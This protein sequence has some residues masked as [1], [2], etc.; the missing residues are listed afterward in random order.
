MRAPL[1]PGLNIEMGAR[2][3]GPQKKSEQHKRA[4]SANIKAGGKGGRPTYETTNADTAVQGFYLPPLEEFTF[5]TFYIIYICICL[6]CLVPDCSL[7]A[8]GVVIRIRCLR[9]F[10]FVCVCDRVLVG[11]RR[12]QAAA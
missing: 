1:S 4:S 12:T 8:P 2:R 11:M 3:G 10:S 5:C 9:L 6:N 7:I